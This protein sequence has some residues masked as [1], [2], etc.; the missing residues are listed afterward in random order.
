[1]GDRSVISIGLQMNQE[2]GSSIFGLSGR[3]LDKRFSS[4]IKIS[5]CAHALLKEIKENK[6]VEQHS[7]TF[8]NKQLRISLLILILLS[9]LSIDTL[10]EI[11]LNSDLFWYARCKFCLS[12]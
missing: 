12:H 2:F 11:P 3:H 5:S 8:T 9:L 4:V 6:D 1:M 10:E 7:L